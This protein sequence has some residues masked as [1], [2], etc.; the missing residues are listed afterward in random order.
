M[1]L[2]K[3][4]LDVA[5]EI[6]MVVA[7]MSLEGR[8]DKLYKMINEYMG[9]GGIVDTTYTLTWFATEFIELHKDSDWE[10]VVMADKGDELPD[11][12]LHRSEKFKK[13]GKYVTCW[14]EAAEDYSEWRVENFNADEFK[15]INMNKNAK[16][17]LLL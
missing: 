11:I 1:K 15:K 3:K 16:N 17:P 12:F 9:L 13:Y 7:L 14:D 4:N 2:D 5:I 8:L 6:G 10:Q